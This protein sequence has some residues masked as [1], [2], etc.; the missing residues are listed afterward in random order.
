MR[1]S[2]VSAVFVCVPFALGLV[3]TDADASYSGTITRSMCPSHLVNDFSSNFSKN[4]SGNGNG[5]W[6]P[7]GD[8]SVGAAGTFGD[9][10]NGW[11]ALPYD[12][13]TA[14][15]PTVTL[16]FAVH[17]TAPAY[18]QQVCVETWSYDAKGQLI[19]LSDTG[20]ICTP[21]WTTPHAQTLTQNATPPPVGGGLMT[22]VQAYQGSSL[23]MVQM[24]WK[25]Q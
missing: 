9:Y 21:T 23:D 12:S 11:V 3:A 15:S 6:G 5:Y 14:A 10:V 19:A 8:C 20:Q 1:R 7:N 18:Q 4:G 22:W 13:E 17:A 16:K 2:L 25:V 24:Q